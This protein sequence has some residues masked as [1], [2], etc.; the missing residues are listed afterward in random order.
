MRVRENAQ[1]SVQHYS[2]QINMIQ[3]DN[4]DDDEINS[5][6]TVHIEEFITKGV[7]KTINKVRRSH[8]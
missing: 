3:Y 7:I 8:L 4:D 1:A 5:L 2:Q 6:F